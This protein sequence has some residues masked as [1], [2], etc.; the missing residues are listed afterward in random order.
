MTMRCGSRSIARTARAASGFLVALGLISIL[1]GPAH[2]QDR[3]DVTLRV[4]SYGG[5]FTAAQRKYVGEIFTQKTGIKVQYID[6]SS[7]EEVAKLMASKGREPPFDVMYMVKDERDA[8]LGLGLLARLDPSIVTNLKYLY[9]EAKNPDGYGPGIAFYSV[10]IAY[11][12]KKFEA[13]G[14]PAPTSWRDLWNPKLAG[15]VGI[16][17]PQLSY[18]REFLLAVTKLLV[19][20]DEST[21]EKGVDY[22]SQIK[23]YSY[24]TSSAPL[25]AAFGSGDVWAAP[26]INAQ[27]WRLI[28]MG[29][30]LRYVIPQEGGVGNLDTIDLVAGS[31]HPKEAQ[32]YINMTLSPLAQLGNA[33]DNPLGPSN[34][35]LVPILEQYPEQAQRFPSSPADLKKLYMPDWLKFLPH[36]D[37]VIDYWN[38]KMSG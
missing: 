10:G 1:A 33:T 30:P 24:Y 8:A 36:R 34:K 6:G 37:D 21:P 19:G 14:I 23:A 17:H 9:D 4:A 38:R 15:R 28:D 11:N 12:Y 27:T 2:A 18:G 29:Q 13:A 3:G 32:L 22:I 7:S 5:A 31:P 20:G 25:T 16:P 35:L 26:M